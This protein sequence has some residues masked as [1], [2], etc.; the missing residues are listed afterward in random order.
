[1]ARRSLD[2]TQYADEVRSRPCFICALVRGEPG[3]E[4]PV[5]YQ[6]EEHIVFLPNWFVQRGYALVAPTEHKEGVVGDFTPEE[7]GSLQLLVHR[8]G[9]AL[10]AI[11]PNERVYVLSLGSQQGNAHVHWHVVVLPPGVPYEQ[12]QYYALMVES[13]GVLD[14]QPDEVK[15]LAQS[16]AAELRR[17]S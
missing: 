7:Y 12:Q 14:I 6:D 10:A 17:S 16:L 2:L 9:R 4:G 8:V 11:H 5:V 1:M 13:A 15:E 3:V